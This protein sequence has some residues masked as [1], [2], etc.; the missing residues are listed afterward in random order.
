M[1]KNLAIAVLALAVVYLVTRALF[2]GFLVTK[3]EAVGVE[4][5]LENAGSEA[6]RAVI[7]DVTGNS[8]KLGDLP[9][10]SSKTVKLDATGDS[11]IELRFSN[12]HQLTIDC[13]FEPAYSGSIKAKI[14]SQA[15][16]A[17]EDEIRSSAY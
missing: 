12:G 16:I 3:A 2:T 17:V 7:V 14:T 11:H 10:G 9:A 5:T 13:Y 4:F 1:K 15:V 6:L 8:Y